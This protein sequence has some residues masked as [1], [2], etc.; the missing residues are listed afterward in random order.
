MELQ[1]NLAQ[2]QTNSTADDLVFEK[3]ENLSKHYNWLIRAK[4][5]KKKKF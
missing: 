2:T 3:L 1:L 5:F 4:F